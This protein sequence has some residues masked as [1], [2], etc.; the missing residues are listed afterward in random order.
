M[1]RDQT[2][3]GA[4]LPIWMAFM[5]EAIAGDPAAEFR[6]PEGIAW[7]GADPET[8]ARV[9]SPVHYDGWVPVAANRDARRPRFVPSP[10]KQKEPE[11]TPAPPI[12]VVAETAAPGSPVAPAP[13]DPSPAAAVFDALPQVGAGPPKTESE[14]GLAEE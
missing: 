3:A 7:A 11:L 10:W 6:V 2:G 12:A 4:A 14:P 13:L 5:E 8:G 9:I 1:A